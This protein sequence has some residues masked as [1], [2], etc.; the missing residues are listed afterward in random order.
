MEGSCLTT[1]KYRFTENRRRLKLAHNAG[2]QRSY[3]LVTAANN[4]ELVIVG[5]EDKTVKAFNF[6]HLLDFN[7]LSPA[8]PAVNFNQYT[9]SIQ[10][11]FVPTL[12][13]VARYGYSSVL[14]VTG[15]DTSLNCPVLEVINLDTQSSIGKLNATELAGSEVIDY[16][17]QP[18]YFDSIVALC[19]NRGHLSILAINK[20]K[21]A[22]ALVY[23]SNQLGALTCCWSPKGKNLA[24]GTANGQILRLEPVIT[25]NSFTFKNVNNSLLVFNHIG[26]KPDHQIVKLRWVNKTYLISVHARPNSP[27]NHETHYSIITVKPSK[28][29]KYWT[30]IC[31]ESVANQDYNV[32]LANLSNAVICTSNSTGEVAVLGLQGDEEARKNDLAD[33]HSMMIYEGAR[34]KIPLN[35]NNMQTY[36]QGLTVAFSKI[37]ILILYTTDAILYAYQAIH[38][39]NILKL[40]EFQEPQV[41]PFTAFPER[42]PT[43][44]VELRQTFQLKPPMEKPPE[45]IK[46]KEQPQDLSTV[47]EKPIKERIPQIPDLTKDLKELRA[48]IN[49]N[50]PNI[51]HLNEVDIL[52]KKLSDVQNSYNLNRQILQKLDQDIDTLDVGM[53]ELLYLIKYIKA[54]S[55]SG[56]GPNKSLESMKVNRVEEMRRKSK[57]IADKLIDLNVNVD[58]AWENFNRQRSESDRQ[59]YD[60]NSLSIIYDTID[61]NEK[62]IK[63][64]KKRITECRDKSNCDSSADTLILPSNVLIGDR[65]D[66]SKLRCFRESLMK[67]NKIPVRRPWAQRDAS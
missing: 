23:N 47:K 21:K 35:N 64:L 57:L 65:V 45:V 9:F 12:L 43:D 49:T 6:N 7:P 36:L 14:L 59:E 25:T 19:T 3:K 17:W 15:Q 62:I 8:V 44:R 18:C 30:Q 4:H 26:L 67:R 39:E 16:A 27:G 11:T 38:N 51:G 61:T 33:W 66:E 1:D 13:T 24:I 5:F 32:H 40:P 53:L 28:P 56:P 29:Y 41:C 52:K 20:D 22:L 48:A 63:H 50:K 54:R 58:V 46:P 55:K 10:L 60:T 42:Q 37:P 31:P 2:P 34:I